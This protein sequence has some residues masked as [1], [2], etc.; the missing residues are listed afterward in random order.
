M[1]RVV[2]G[3]WDYILM[4]PLFLHFDTSWSNGDICDRQRECCLTL[5]NS[6]EEN[7]EKDDFQGKEERCVFGKEKQVGV[8]GSSGRGGKLSS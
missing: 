4:K 5:R 6:K 8:R 2:L 1:S 7:P 3:T